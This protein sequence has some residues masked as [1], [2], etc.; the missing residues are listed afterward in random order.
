M[1]NL[2]QS[3]EVCPQTCANC[4]VRAV[5]MC[6]ALEVA[7]LAE[8]SRMLVT[9]PLAPKSMLFSEGE[10]AEHVYNVTT[11]CIR[12]SKD[13]ADGRRQIVGF[14]L[15]GDFLNLSMEK[16][17]GFSADAVE[18]TSLCRFQSGQFR[19]YLA[20]KP[21]LVRRL[22][23]LAAHEL[24]I[25]QS[26][27]VLLGRRRAEEKIAA[28]LLNWRDRLGKLTGADHTLHLPM[29]RQDMA[30]HLG[31]T[32]ETVSRTMSNLARRKVIIVI[33][34]GIRILHLD[35]LRALAG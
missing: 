13:L 21:H 8:L 12:L 32:I 2:C 26:Q 28:F 18:N 16:T 30:D 27:M 29:T 24:T 7:D 19:K 5:G 17:Y 3:V 22:Y 20:E 34:E 31:L 33:P 4:Q 11:G 23:D 35:E 9:T 10:P 1:L 6:G 25:A 14:A 15:P